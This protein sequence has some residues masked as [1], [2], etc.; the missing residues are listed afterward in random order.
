MDTAHNTYS[1]WAKC[2]HRLVTFISKAKA[3]SKS[4][5]NKSLQQMYNQ[6]YR[7][8]SKFLKRVNNEH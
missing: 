1:N 3:K 4:I 2:S 7:I 8:R 6:Y 5:T